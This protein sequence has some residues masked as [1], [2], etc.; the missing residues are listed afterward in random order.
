MGVGSL[1]KSLKFI[2]N[3]KGQGGTTSKQALVY[4]T[5]EEYDYSVTA[6]SSRCEGCATKQ[7]L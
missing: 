5:M 4:E 2:I 7:D 3:N 1:V 6:S